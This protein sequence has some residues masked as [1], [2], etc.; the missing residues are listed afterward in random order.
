ML[1]EHSLLKLCTF[2]ETWF[3]R[4]GKLEMFILVISHALNVAHS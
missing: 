4:A 3:L 2:S 1:F